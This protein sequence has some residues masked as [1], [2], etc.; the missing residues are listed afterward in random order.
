[1]PQILKRLAKVLAI[2]KKKRGPLAFFLNYLRNMYDLIF[3]FHSK[4][5]CI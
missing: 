3:F 4:I 2:A 1:M 5:P